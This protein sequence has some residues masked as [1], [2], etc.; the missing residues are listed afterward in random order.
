MSHRH[1]IELSGIDLRNFLFIIFTILILFFFEKIYHTR[2]DL[3]QETLRVFKALAIAFLIIFSILALTNI[4]YSKLFIV[5]YFGLLFFTLPIFKRYFKKFI[6]KYL[7]IREK[8]LV[9]GKE[10][11]QKKIKE[12]L[13]NNWYLGAKYSKENYDKVI[14][15][16][17]GYSFEE[18]DALIN[19]YMHK[20]GD[21]FIVPYL[22][23]INFSHSNILEFTNL[24]LSTIELQNK[25]LIKHNIAIKTVFDKLFSISI[26]PFFLIIHLIIVLLI[27]KDS[28]GEIF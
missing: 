23:H 19:R 7:N 14:I 5:T 3:W 26:L 2:Y 22:H 13:K 8:I 28:K 21:V 12:E 27:K 6:F 1:S 11:E 20:V 25:L 18:L 4:E 15:V 10:E 24:R 9:V 17:A 16:S